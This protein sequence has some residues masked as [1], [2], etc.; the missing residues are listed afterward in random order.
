[1]DARENAWAERREV[2]AMFSEECVEKGLKL[3]ADTTEI[4]NV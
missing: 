1:M 3:S 4:A 2:F